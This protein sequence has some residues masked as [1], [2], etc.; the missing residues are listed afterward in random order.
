MSE[1]LRTNFAEQRRRIAEQSK[2]VDA[3]VV[4]LE[5]VRE[6][7]ASQSRQSAEETAKFREA[8]ELLLGKTNAV[9]H[10]ILMTRS[11]D[12]WSL[13]FS[14]LTS[15]LLAQ[16]AYGQAT[17]DEPLF[18]AMIHNFERLSEEMT[19]SFPDRSMIM[20]GWQRAIKGM[21][22]GKAPELSDKVH[23][24]SDSLSRIILTLRDTGPRLNFREFYARSENGL[25]IVRPA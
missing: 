19:K 23:P 10:D 9:C 17:Q 20:N 3:K 6:S 16:L 12:E 11:C 8:Y 2:A 22:A 21:G 15:V 24:Q 14:Y 18:R 13:A 1:P 25:H 7:R 4:H 5:K